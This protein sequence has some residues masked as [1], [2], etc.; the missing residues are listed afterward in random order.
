MVSASHS[1]CHLVKISNEI[2]NE[3]AE[4]LEMGLSCFLNKKTGQLIAIPNDLDFLGDELADE[5]EAWQED[6]QI[7]K[8]SPDNFVQIE[9]MTSSDSFRIMEDFIETVVD[10]QLKQEL[11]LSIQMKKP[12]AHFKSA[13]G[14]SA[15]ERER[16]FE[17]KK[18]QFIEWIKDQLE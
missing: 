2:L 8:N 4:D 14:S 16:W 9:N 3:I 11:L 10:G 13:I 1:N 17:F 12:F 5:S 18:Q 6:I 7:I 15:N